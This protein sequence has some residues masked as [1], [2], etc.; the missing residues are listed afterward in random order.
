LAKDVS[1][2]GRAIDV[3]ELKDHDGDIEVSIGDCIQAR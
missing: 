1:P 2:R 3:A